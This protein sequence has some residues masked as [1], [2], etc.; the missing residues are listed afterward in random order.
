MTNYTRNSSDVFVRFRHASGMQP[1]FV[2]SAQ[3]FYQQCW[4]ITDNSNEEHVIIASL[5]VEQ[6]H[7]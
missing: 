1:E 5:S 3:L 6:R 2:S 7:N 4:L